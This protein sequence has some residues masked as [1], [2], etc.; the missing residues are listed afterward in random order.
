ML[1]I[2]SKFSFID[3]MMEYIICSSRIK[4]VDLPPLA[5]IFES[6]SEILYRQRQGK[7][8]GGKIRKKPWLWQRWRR[9]LLPWTIPLHS[10]TSSTTLSGSW[11]SAVLMISRKNKPHTRATL[12]WHPNLS[13]NFCNHKLCRLEETVIVDQIGFK[14]PRVISR[15]WKFWQLLKIY[16]QSSSVQ[17]LQLCS[18]ATGR[19]FLEN[20]FKLTFL[21]ISS[22][23]FP[24]FLSSIRL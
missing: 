14:S 21:R 12:F 20:P 19:Q 18:E 5:Q 4:S 1:A 13:H 9:L 24:Q 8:V 22:T 15:V 7:C 6:F 11:N 16:Q 17:E 2:L 3:G 10:F 23:N